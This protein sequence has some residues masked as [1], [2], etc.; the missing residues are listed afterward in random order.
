MTK[1]VVLT[2]AGFDGS[3]GAGIQA[4]IKTISALKAYA[5]SVLTALPVQN[6]LG[7]KHCYTLPAQAIEDQLQAVYE[8]IKPDAIKVGMLFNNDVIDR[9]YLFLKNKAYNIPIVV[10]PV[11]V[12]NSGHTLLNP[13]A[14]KNLLHKILPLA[15]IITPNIPEAKMLTHRSIDSKKDM[16]SVAN[17]LCNMFPHVGIYLKGGHIK[18]VPMAVDLCV[19]KK[20]K[21]WYEKPFITTKNTHGTGCT[22]SAAI[23]TFLAYGKKVEES[24]QLAK[25]YI[26]EALLSGSRYTIGKGAG[27]LDHFV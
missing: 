22:L 1:T 10:D 8:D 6:T 12:S 21:L 11:M 20:K 18:N 5:T 7:V 24:C 27:P 23:A 3:G 26:Y 19:Y 4:D 25:N 13:E 15:T 9:V 14:V 16:I 2:I 17:I